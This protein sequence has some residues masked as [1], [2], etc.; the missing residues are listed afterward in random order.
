MFF[1]T[2][3]KRTRHLKTN[4]KTIVNTI[5]TPT[6]QCFFLEKTICAWCHK[7]ASPVTANM[8]TP[9]PSA[10]TAV[11]N[12]RRWKL[13]TFSMSILP[14][15]QWCCDSKL[16]RVSYQHWRSWLSYSY[17]KFKN[18]L[19][20][21][22]CT[23]LLDD[24]FA[25]IRS[26]QCETWWKNMLLKHKHAQTTNVLEHCGIQQ[27]ISWFTTVN[28]SA[29]NHLDLIIQQLTFRLQKSDNYIF[30]QKSAT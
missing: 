20:F 11:D 19:L 6:H 18:N 12:T 27:P 1:Q 26:K 24:G 8:A 28:S 16:T 21:P 17:S 7:N 14:W 5:S 22:F 30:S 9:G 15:K 13:V 2:T 10:L 25:A 4:H 3:S 29:E 23:S